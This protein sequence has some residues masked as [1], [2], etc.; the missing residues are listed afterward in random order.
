MKRVYVVLFG[1][2]LSL[3]ILLVAIL[4]SNRIIGRPGVYGQAGYSLTRND[5]HVLWTADGRDFF[6]HDAEDQ[7][8]MKVNPELRYMGNAQTVFSRVKPTGTFRIFCVGGSTTQGWPFHQVLSYPKLLG[9]YLSDLL[10]GK[11]I[12][13]I[14]AGFM[15]ADIRTDNAI[16]KEL[17]RY[18]PDMV[19][20]Y[21]GRTDAF[22]YPFHASRFS[23]LIDIQTFLL[24]NVYAYGYCRSRME[25]DTFDHARSV[26]DFFMQALD[27]PEDR[28]KQYFIRDAMA[29][30]D[31]CGTRQCSLVLLEQVV[32]S[33]ER[34][35]GHLVLRM[36]E[37]MR[38]FAR[39]NRVPLIE[40]DTAFRGSLLPEEELIIPFAVHP[41]YKGYALLA[42]TVCRGLAGMDMIAPRGEWRWQALKNDDDYFR[43]LGLTDEF[44]YDTYS[45]S[46][47]GLFARLE[48]G[49]FKAQYH[50]I[51]RRYAQ[52]G[53]EAVTR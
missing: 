38:E 50:E 19:I 12:E 13:V 28:I 16:V 36:N 5:L 8:L 34:K 3:G 52:S 14:N 46:V 22:N 11:K 53:A 48:L 6:V 45:R 39:Q 42:Q 10:P 18:Q 25:S 37:W 7:A 26:R 47:L 1:T 2:L 15:G 41:D 30:A 51:A 24:R 29:L 9:L 32:H 23:W 21:E 17:L 49:D 4:V 35:G 40:V 20:A 31:L 27:H 43:Q 44:L 33:R